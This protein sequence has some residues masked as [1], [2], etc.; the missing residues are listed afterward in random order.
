VAGLTTWY[1][2]WAEMVAVMKELPWV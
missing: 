2:G 1:V